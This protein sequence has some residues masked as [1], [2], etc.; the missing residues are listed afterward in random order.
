MSIRYGIRW[1]IVGFGSSMTC[2]LFQ[3]QIFLSIVKQRATT[4]ITYL[5]NWLDSSTVCYRR[6]NKGL[7]CLLWS[8][9]MTMCCQII[10]NF[11]QLL[12]ESFWPGHGCWQLSTR[13]G[14]HI[15]SE[16]SNETPVSF[17]RSSR[18]LCCRLWLPFE[19]WTGVEL[20]LSSNHHRGRRPCATAS[21]GSSARWSFGSWMDQ[22]HW[23]WRLP[24]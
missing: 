5:V 21:P 11:L 16:N 12:M 23:D 15:W 14:V 20:F 8:N 17:W 24:V 9:G 2:V 4:G 6:S 13:L 19:D 3:L 7:H 1:V 10:P 22:G 18:P